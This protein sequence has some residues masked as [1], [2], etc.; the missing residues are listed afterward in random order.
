MEHNLSKG[1]QEMVKLWRD[2]SDDEKGA[3]LLAHHKRK[4]IEYFSCGK[5]QTC[6]D[7]RPVWHRGDAYRVKPEPK[8]E[9]TKLMMCCVPEAI[10]YISAFMSNPT[11]YITFKTI[12]GKPDTQSVKMEEV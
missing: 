1:D 2:M 5:W 6:L 3:L 11:H 8:V 9:T 4:V 12:D 10:S 7:G